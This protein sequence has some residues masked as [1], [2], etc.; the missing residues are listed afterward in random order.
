MEFSKARE[1]SESQYTVETFVDEMEDEIQYTQLYLY[2]MINFLDE[3]KKLIG[4]ELKDEDK[5]IRLQ[6]LQQPNYKLYESKFNDLVCKNVLVSLISNLEYNITTLIALMVKENIIKENFKKPTDNVII[7]SL[8]FLERELSLPKKY[9][10]NID[11]LILIRNRIIHHNSKIN[12]A[13]LSNRN[14]D[15]IENYV[16]ITKD[17]FTFKD[18]TKNLFLLKVIRTIFNAIESNI[19]EEK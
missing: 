3:K 4:Q 7:K 13:I 14:F 9:F 16:N 1:I 5:F 18:L 2:D 8:K 11:L 6:L 19:S 10:E 15:L 12:N 17:N